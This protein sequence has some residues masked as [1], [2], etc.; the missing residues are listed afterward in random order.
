MKID[1]LVQT[2]IKLREK[3]SQLDAEYEEKKRGFK[4]AQEKI[5][6]LMLTRFGE[7]GVD[8]MKTANGT[9]YV[10]VRSSATVAD[11]DSFREF[12]ERQ[13][14][15]HMFVERRVSKTAVEQYKAAHEGDLPPGV[16]WREERVVNFRRT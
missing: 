10:S 13:T 2:Y 1:E 14:D 5:E 16:N 12:L 11:W 8:S 9:A 15:P 3:L 4:A 6:A 7:M